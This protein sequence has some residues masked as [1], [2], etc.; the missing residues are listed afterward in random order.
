MLEF[1]QNSSRMLYY[2]LN[3]NISLNK[4]LA[5]IQLKGDP[6][7]PLENLYELSVE[8]PNKYCYQKYYIDHHF[9]I[10]Y[11]IYYNF[12]KFF[13][14]LKSYSRIKNIRKKADKNL[15]L[16]HQIYSTNRISL[17]LQHD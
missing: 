9:L 6:F 4:I 5:N 16:F 14:L 11:I 15:S 2:H 3:H 13:P 17:V 1:V 7:D 12:L 10:L 8:L